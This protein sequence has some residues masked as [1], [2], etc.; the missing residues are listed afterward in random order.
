MTTKHPLDVSYLEK[1]SFVEADWLRI[2]PNR[3]LGFS[4]YAEAR[5]D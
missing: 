5:I 3:K 1:E 4:L 2:R